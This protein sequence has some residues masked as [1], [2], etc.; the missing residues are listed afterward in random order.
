M[1]IGSAVFIGLLLLSGIV[2]AFVYKVPSCTDLKQNQDETGVDCGGSCAYLCSDTVQAPRVQFARAVENGAGRTDVIAYIENRNAG[3][4][5]NDAR[6]TVEVFATDGTPLG[7]RVGMIDIPARSTIALYVPGVAAAGGVRA[8][9]SFEDTLR[10]RTARSANTALVVS[11]VDRVEGNRP[12]I[13]AVLENPEPEA[14]YNRTVIATVFDA[15]GE[16]IAVSQTVVRE[17]P[18]L[19]TTE[20]VFTWNAPYRGQGARVEIMT[21]PELP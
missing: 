3:A 20:A 4:E 7:T 13:T 9:V 16:A 10:W 17:V 6:Y 1:V 19:G 18:A 11:R 14:Q 21:V 15:G 2:I 12:R 5:A 8:F